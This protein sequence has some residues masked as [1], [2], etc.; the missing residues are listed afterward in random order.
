[1]YEY[2]KTEVRYDSAS[3]RWEIYDGMT[4]GGGEND[5]MPMPS[6]IYSETTTADP[7][8]SGLNWYYVDSEVE[9][10]A[11]VT[12]TLA[13][14][15]S[16]SG[17]AS[18]SSS[19]D[20]SSSESSSSSGG[21]TSGINFT[22]DYSEDSTL[23]YS[24]TFLPTEY[25]ITV[26]EW[27]N[28]NHRT[29]PRAVPLYSG[30]FHVTGTE[31]DWSSDEPVEVA[32]DR[33][34]TLWLMPVQTMETTSWWDYETDADKAAALEEEGNADYF[35]YFAWGINDTRASSL[36]SVDVIMGYFLRTHCVVPP[37]ANTNSVYSE[38]AG[39]W[40]NCTITVS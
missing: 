2:S 6:T 19:E 21:A 9:H 25:T 3:G 16:G 33:Y 26:D 7:W 22:G 10:S 1:M 18:S 34:E 35:P 39:S 23:H 15:G 28:V 40:D 31:M 24:G 29:V 12:I 14:G 13:N 36:W 20:S 37:L 11:T 17:D 5:W 38:A 30:S 8:T 32:V 4:Q 27:D